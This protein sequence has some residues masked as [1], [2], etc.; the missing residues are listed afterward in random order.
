MFINVNR[1]SMKRTNFFVLGIVLLTVFNCKTSKES[2]L[3][4]QSTP[5]LEI[6]A[7]YYNSWV[8]GVQGGGAGI[9]V[10]LPVSDI[11]N[12]VVDSIHFRGEK[13]IV[14]KKGSLIVGRFKT[15]DNQS[16][17]FIVSSNPEDEYQNRLVYKADVSPFVLANT[18]CVISYRVKDKRLYY[19]ISN[20]KQGLAE[21]YPSVP[22][23]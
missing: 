23:N 14:E 3:Q 1:N 9:N 5:P 20:L 17:D 15:T 4:F 11:R 13:A 18:E 12:I 16:R 21:A 6:S 10:F 19:K 2:V 7:P 22:P 8:A